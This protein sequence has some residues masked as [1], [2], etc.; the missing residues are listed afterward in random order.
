MK[1]KLF[2]C[3]LALTMLTVLTACGGKAANSSASASADT[4]EAMVPDYTKNDSYASYTGSD[5]GS[6]GFDE[7][8]SLPTDAAEQK[9]IYTGDLNL[10]TTDFD[11]ATRS[12]SALA[13]ELGGYVENSSIGSSSRGYRWA[14]YTIRIPSGQFQRF[15]EQAGE[16]AHETWRSTIESA[17]SETEWNIENLSG[18]LRRYDSQVALSTI[19][20]NLQ[21][22][23]KYSNTENVPESFGERIGS[24]LTRGWSAFTDTVEN[25]LV[26]LAYGWTWLVLLAVIGVTA[27]V[28]SRRALRRRQEKRKA[29]AEKTDDKTGQ[30]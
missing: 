19:T 9:I 20:V 11:A 10:E 14:D 6:G 7:T 8:E 26:A 27:A 21:E 1:R 25:I 4:S 5:S 13:E 17:I 28:C 29:S 3:F 30:V 24:A 18:T 16:L 12:L 22:V 15:F 2:A 23:Y